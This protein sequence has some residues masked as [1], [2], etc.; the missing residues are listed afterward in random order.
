[1]CFKVVGRY[2]CSHARPHPIEWGFYRPG[3]A[4]GNVT[5]ITDAGD[6]G[7]R[8]SLV[9]GRWSSVVGRWSLV[10]SPWSLAIQSSA[11]AAA[12]TAAAGQ[13][14]APVPTWTSLPRTFGGRRGL[15]FPALR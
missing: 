2:E 3:D 12:K 14:R 7:S 15:L 13:A 9:V 4:K 6:E 8:W 5:A 1:M 10:V 11:A